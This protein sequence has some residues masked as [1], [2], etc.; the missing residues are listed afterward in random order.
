MLIRV[1]KTYF[2]VGKLSTEVSCW[3][4]LPL[5]S[6]FRVSNMDIKLTVIEPPGMEM[7]KFFHVPHFPHLLCS[8]DAL[9]SG[10]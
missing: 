2:S 3:R 9:L 7:G 1:V 6:D 8:K 10:P 4:H 5:L